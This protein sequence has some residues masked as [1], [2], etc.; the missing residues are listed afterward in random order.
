MRRR[1]S[2]SRKPAGERYKLQD[3]CADEDSNAEC[4]EEDCED[5]NQ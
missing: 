4:G 3:T 5:D 2:V 1:H